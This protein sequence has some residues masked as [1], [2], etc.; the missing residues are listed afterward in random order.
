MNESFVDVNKN[1]QQEING[2]YHFSEMTTKY[3]RVKY[4]CPCCHR[5]VPGHVAYS[6]SN[7]VSIKMPKNIALAPTLAVELAED[8]INEMAYFVEPKL[9]RICPSCDKNLLG[10]FEPVDGDI[11]YALSY[12]NKAGCETFQSCS[13]HLYSEPYIL[14]KEAYDWINIRQ[15]VAEAGYAIPKYWYGRTVSTVVVDDKNCRLRQ[16]RRLLIS[17]D[18]KSLTYGEYTDGIYLHDITTFARHLY[19]VKKEKERMDEANGK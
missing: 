6:V 10:K 13:G 16:K 4:M 17:V 15:L 19:K 9:T 5:L 3:N 8:Y 12:F 11:A 18:Q 7:N 14:F 2:F 1:V